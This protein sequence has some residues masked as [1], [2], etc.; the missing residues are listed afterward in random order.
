VRA[1]RWAGLVCGAAL[2]AVACTG[3]GPSPGSGPTTAPTSASLPPGAAP[4]LFVH[5]YGT[6][7]A[8]FDDMIAHLEQ[9]G[10]PSSYLKAVELDPNDGSNIDAATRE[11]APAVEELVAAVG[12][13]PAA[14]IDIVAHSM[15]AL[16]SRWYAA[17]LRPERVR[18]LLTVVGANHG[19]DQLCDQGT[20]G[21]ADLCPA[22]AADDG[23]PV[24]VGL[25]GRPDQ[26]ADETP[27]GWA[28][29]R[30]GV[31]TVPA[32]ATRAIRYVAVSILD[33]Q[34]IRPLA[35]S[36]LAGASPV[37]ALPADV[38]VTQTTPGNLMFGEPTDHDLILENERFFVLLD[39]LLF[40][41]GGL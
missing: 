2:C 36:A 30:P 7:A 38:D 6:S 32:D 41:S 40:G 17:K 15:G 8:V 13:G 12:G 21:T 22:F 16:S 19:T 23:H 11:L 27:Y 5:G 29:D 14:K 31:R 24:Q 39:A 25:N 37:P 4:V 3:P 34:W 18:M 26:P 9:S 35:S 28:A 33:D 10:Y 1:A 20:G